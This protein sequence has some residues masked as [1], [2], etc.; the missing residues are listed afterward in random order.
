MSYD[1]RRREEDYYYNPRPRGRNGSSPGPEVHIH[2]VQENVQDAREG[3]PVYRDR[4]DRPYYAQPQY[5]PVIPGAFP[6]QQPQLSPPLGYERSR[7]R[8][9]GRRYSEEEE[10]RRIIEDYK[11][12]QAEEDRRRKAAVA[13]AE[14]R[15]KDEEEEREA[16]AKKAIEKYKRDLAEKE[17]KEKKRKKEEQERVK[18]GLARAFAK[19]EL[20]VSEDTIG[21]LAEGKDVKNNELIVAP[22]PKQQPVW[23]R[24]R[25]SEIS[26][27]TLKFY[28]LPYYT[29]PENSDYYIIKQELTQNEIDVLYERSRR[30]RHRNSGPVIEAGPGERLQIVRPARSRSRNDRERSRNRSKSRG[31]AE[32][33]A[34]ALARFAT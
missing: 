11:Y 32:K 7:S 14:R 30:H 27:D 18:L 16:A 21:R 2:N 17:E 20:P 3:R 4:Y 28:D 6:V 26:A 13:E 1:R 34:G 33:F 22:V 19:M 10:R 8:S 5:I 12:Q 23:Q 25:R 29:D 24:V 9:R 31:A 15:R